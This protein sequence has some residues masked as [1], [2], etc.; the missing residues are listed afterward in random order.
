MVGGRD[1]TGCRTCKR[2]KVRCDRTKPTCLRCAAGLFFCE[3]Y[4]IVL[5]DGSRSG[6]HTEKALHSASNTRLLPINDG[7]RLQRLA[8]TS[9]NTAGHGLWDF[10]RRYTVNEI[11]CATNSHFWKVTVLAGAE[12][13][14]AIF[15][16]LLALS[17]AHSARRNT[18][19]L[20]DGQGLQRT[21]DINS[22]L[23]HYYISISRLRGLLEDPSGSDKIVILIVCLLLVYFDL[24]VGR[25]GESYLH[26]K[27]GR[28]ILTEIL[29]GHSTS[30]SK[31]T[32]QL[33]PISCDPINELSNEFAALDLQSVNYGSW[34][35]LFMLSDDTSQEEPR[36]PQVFANI[37]Q[38]WAYLTILHN[39][40]HH[41][42]GV[43]A[44][45]GDPSF[46][47]KPWDSVAT[48]RQSRLISLLRRWKLSFDSSPIRPTSLRTARPNPT[49]HKF[50]RCQLLYQYLWIVTENAH[51]VAHEME[52]DRLLP[53]FTHIVDLCEE[54]APTLPS[55]TIE[56]IIIQPLFLVGC[57]CRHPSIRRRCLQIL[58][59][60][61]LEGHWDSALIRLV[62]EIK[63]Q[64]EEEEAGYF[65]D[66]T[67][68]S[69]LDALWLSMTIPKSARYSDTLMFFTDADY[70]V[71]EVQ[72][73]RDRKASRHIQTGDSGDFEIRKRIVSWPP[74]AT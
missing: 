5:A 8:A 68:Q 61:R 49:W 17:I 74:S 4:G 28:I 48:L 57:C 21:K 20:F 66:S 45:A 52:Y 18:Q 24:I 69:P 23:K 67:E 44:R 32:L 70:R 16:A 50:Q 55:I 3:G 13:E 25:F 2:R 37:E 43:D 11:V 31:P 27:N 47:R 58:S 46:R 33:I 51:H 38:A 39:L 7:T 35:T 56:S 60:P 63:M 41:V 73:R 26:L 9:C 6:Q 30:T 62:T 1:R 15:Q 72:L 65:H 29:Q 34:H 12:N 22:A 59:I 71:L 42:A 10:C 54:L 19:R 36:M 64:A 40:L 14:P 53:Q